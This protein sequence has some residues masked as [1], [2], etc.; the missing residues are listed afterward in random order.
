MVLLRQ[1]NYGQQINF[2]LLQP[3]N[4]LQ[5]PNVL[6]A[7]LNILLSQQNVFVPILTN[8][9]VSI[10]KPF[11][12]WI[13]RLNSRSPRGEANLKTQEIENATFGSVEFVTTRCLTWSNFLHSNDF[14]LAMG[15]ESGSLC[16]VYNKFTNTRMKRHSFSKCALRKAVLSLI[17]RLRRVVGEHPCRSKGKR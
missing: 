10:T 15:K 5:Q 3:K 8:Y 4:F 12:P 7:E 17:S 6:L 14:I 16:Q 2:L 9:F 1:Q 13:G 11:F